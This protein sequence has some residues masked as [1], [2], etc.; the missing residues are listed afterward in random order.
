MRNSP[1]K[2]LLFRFKPTILI[3]LSLAFCLITACGQTKEQSKKPVSKYGGVLYFA[4]ETPFHGFDIFSSGGLLI[5]SMSMLVNLIQEPLFRMDK[6]G[7]LIPV[8]GLSA[9]AF[10]KGKVWKIKLRAGVSFHDGEPFNA[11]AVIQHWQRMLLPENKYRGRRLFEP[12]RSVEKVDDHTVRFILTHPW[13]AFLKVLSDELYL[14]AFIPSPKAVEEEVH[15][16]KPVGT[17]PF[18]FYRWRSGNHFVVSKN[19]NYWQEGKPYLNKVVFRI[20][21]DH[22]TRYAS[23]MAGQLDA[24][25]I[26]R[27]NIINKSKKDPDLFVYEIE[28]NGA[29]IVLVNMDRPPLNDIRVRHAL[30]Y[31]NNQRLHIKMVYNNSIPF[32]DSPYGKSFD[33]M[34]NDYPENDAETAKKLIAEYGKPVEFELIHSNTSRGKQTGELLQQL[35]KEIGVKLNPVPLGTAPHVMRVVQKDYQLATWRIPSSNDHGPQLYRSFHSKSPTNYSGYNK[36]EMDDL[37]EMQ[38]RETDPEM[39]N[40]LMCEISALI[41]QDI[42]IYYRGGRRYH[43]IAKKK[44]IDIVDVAGI[45]LNLASAWIDYPVK[46]NTLAYEFEQQSGIDFECPDPGDTDAVKAELVGDWQGKDDWGAEI[47]AT[48]FQDDRVV[49]QRKGSNQRENKYLICGSKIFWKAGVATVFVTLNGN[50]IEGYWEKA[51]YKGNFVLT[52]KNGGSE[53]AKNG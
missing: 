53:T 16:T 28:G 24:I 46:F 11:D 12:I 37:L 18:K 3:L 5:P 31:A 6:Q 30:A 47:T 42:P 33:C 43:I 52:R 34:E 15:N 4:V 39:R 26:D 9:E 23:L 25:T 2:K 29:E 51:G 20:I 27:G 21:P 19:E 45:K 32:V 41:N 38:R 22:Q 10:D 17:G 14:C 35:Y 44:I 36:P 13:P 1:S 40:R 8:L 48:F 7:Q 49:S 50:K